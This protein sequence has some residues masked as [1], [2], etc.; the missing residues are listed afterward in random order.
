MIVRRLARPMLAAIFI[1]GGIDQLRRPQ[2]K[3]EAAEK[4]KPQLAQLGVPT[5]DTELLVRANGAA[6]VAGGAM[7]ALGRFPRLSS[8]GLLATLVPTTLTHDFWA[9][10]DPQAK[11]MHQTQ[12]LKNLGLMGGLLLAS[13]DTAGKPGLTY[14]AGMAADA[15]GRTAHNAKL[16]AKLAAANAKNALPV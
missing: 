14:R 8:L 1:A 6:M 2:A 9:Q 4:I 11:Q 7:L 12:F 5:D 13:V 10:S 15:V 16:E 3:T